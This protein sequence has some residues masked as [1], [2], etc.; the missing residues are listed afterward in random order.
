MYMA[1]EDPLVGG[2][3]LGRWEGTRFAAGLPTYGPDT[4]GD[5][6]PEVPGNAVNPNC[7]SGDTVAQLANTIELVRVDG[8]LPDGSPH[9]DVLLRDNPL[10]PSP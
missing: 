6:R 1:L 5:G 4:D 2:V 10:P 7:T 9:A 3:L 8:F